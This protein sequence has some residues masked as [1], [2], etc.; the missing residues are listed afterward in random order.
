MAAGK[1]EQEEEER[2][3]RRKRT[4]VAGRDVRQNKIRNEAL[5]N[6]K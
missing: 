2:K 3:R 4:Q 6:I 1:Q 5:Q